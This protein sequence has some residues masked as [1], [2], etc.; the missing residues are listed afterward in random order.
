MTTGLVIGKFLPPHRGHMHLMEYARACVQQ[1]VV[2]VYSIQAQSIPGALRTQWLRE[3][4]PDVTVYH[5][6]DEIPQYPYEHPDFWNIFV[7]TVRRF[8]SHGPDWVF[9]SEEYGEELAQRL[10]AQHAM[11]DLNRE[12]YPISGTAVRENP[13]TN[14]HLI[15]EPV[16]AHYARKITFIGAESTGKTTLSLQ[17]AAHLGATWIPEYGRLY[18]E[19]YRSVHEQHDMDLIFRGQMA[20]EDWG[21]RRANRLLICDTD[22]LTSCVWNERYYQHYPEWMNREFE[23]RKS[24]LHLLCNIDLPWIYDGVRDSGEQRQWFHRRFLEELHTRQLPYVLIS[25]QGEARFDAALA[26]IRQHFPEAVAA[27]RADTPSL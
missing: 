1:L 20:L 18:Y 22:T 27:L 12:T 2:I 7:G 13:Y 23:A 26:A 15:P 4:Y 19:M 21:M 14:W 16:R 24:H 11:V 17:I 5:C 25:G 6:D 10:G 3:L 9:T 8:L